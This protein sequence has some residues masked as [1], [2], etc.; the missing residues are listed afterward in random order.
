MG[1]ER[2]DKKR[3]ERKAAN[4]AARVG[5]TQTGVRQRTTS[6][7]LFPSCIVLKVRQA[8]L[9]RKSKRITRK[10]SAKRTLKTS[11]RTR[12]RRKS[13]KAS[14]TVRL[15]EPKGSRIERSKGKAFVLEIKLI[16]AQG[17]CQ[18]TRRRRR[19]R[20]AAISH[21]EPQIGYDPWISE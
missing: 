3:E 21:G 19:T 9:L 1:L 5:K 2:A 11:Y 8:N 12:K 10:P 13:S 20:S 18:G 17:E 15:A 4:R 16:R 6:R 14:K 7:L